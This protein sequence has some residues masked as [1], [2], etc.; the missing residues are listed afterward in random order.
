MR[1]S[2]RAALLVAL[3]ALTLT[4]TASAASL[5]QQAYKAG[6]AAYVYGYP[7]VLSALTATKIPGQTLVSVDNISSP[8]NRVIVLPNVDTA[9]TAANLDLSDQP[10]VLHVPAIAGRYYVFE[11]LDAYTN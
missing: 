1:T 11:L 2:H 7:T 3:A 6:L 10:F 4:T 8:E 5:E 9:Y